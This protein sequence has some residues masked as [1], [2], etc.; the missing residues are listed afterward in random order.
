[1]ADTTGEGTDLAYVLSVVVR[2]ASHCGVVHDM[3]GRC[4]GLCSLCRRG[5]S[6]PL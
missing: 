1:M 3:C 4:S 6:Q 5:L 2:S